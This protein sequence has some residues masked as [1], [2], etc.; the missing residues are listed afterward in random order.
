MTADRGKKTYERIALLYDLLDLPFEYGRYRA[1]RP[2]LFAGLGGRILEAGVGTGRNIEFYPPDASVVGV[3]ISPAMLHRASRRR[4]RTRAEVELLEMD[5]TALRF[6][7]ASF[8]AVVATFVCCTL[9][10]ALQRQALGELARVVKPLGVIRLLDYVPPQGRLRR[11]IAGLWGPWVAWAFGA[12]F[13]HDTERYLA[14]AGLVTVAARYVVPDLIRLV[15]V[16][17]L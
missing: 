9:P 13:D 11:F 14:Q 2:L 17:P 16:K 7:D 10:D 1:I 12:R 8:D 3:D 5:I 15:E 6:P 4:S